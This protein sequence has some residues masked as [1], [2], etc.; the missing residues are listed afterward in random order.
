MAYRIETLDNGEWTNDAS[1]LGHGLSQSDN[2]FASELE[3]TN[4]IDDLIALGFRPRD[5]R[6]IKIYGVRGL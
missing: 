1:L 5:L 3:A 4:A 2:E 6:C